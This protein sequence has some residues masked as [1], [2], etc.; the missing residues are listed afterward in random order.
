MASRNKNE[1]AEELSIGIKK[2]YFKDCLKLC[3]G[4]QELYDRSGE[5]VG[6]AFEPECKES[7]F[8][9]ND[10][11]RINI[12]P[13][14]CHYYKSRLESELEKYETQK[15]ERRKQKLQE[16]KENWSR[17]LNFAG[18]PFTWFSKLAGITQSLLILLLIL[19]FA[20]SWVPIIIEL[21]RALSGK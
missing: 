9:W 4:G 15:E 18:I 7:C 1:I 13:P 6:I 17:W 19:L 21:I 16:R 14:N 10:P 11:L 3:V 8:I 5:E 2:G 12:C 20:R